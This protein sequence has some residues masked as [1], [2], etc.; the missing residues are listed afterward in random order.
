[1][2]WNTGI[3]LLLLAALAVSAPADA[4][5]RRQQTKKK[6]EQK[7]KKDSKKQ[8]GKTKLQPENPRPQR[9]TG[10]ND[11]T[12]RSTTFE[13]EQIYKPEIKPTP[14]P[15]LTPTMPPAAVQRLNQQ[16]EVPQQALNYTYRSLPIRPL[17]LGKDTATPPPASYIKA[18]GGNLSTIFGDIG[19]GGFKGGNWE[20][21]FHAHHISQKGDI[22]GQKFWHTGLDA[23]GTLHTNGH[24]WKALLDVDY[25]RVG[26]Y[27]Y[28][29]DA[30]NYSEDN[31]NRT[32]TS[33]GLLLG[34]K[35]EETGVLGLD[36]DAFI[37]ANFSAG[38]SL[39]GER[40]IELNVPVSKKIDESFSV[41]LGMNALLTQLKTDSNQNNN[42]FQLTPAF[43][44]MKEQFAAHFGLSPTF[45]KG[46]IAY[47]LPDIT[48]GYQ[49]NDHFKVNAGWQAK[50]IQNTFQ[51]LY[52]RNMFL[53]G[54]QKV[55]QTRSDEVF[56]AFEAGIGKH[57]SIN[58][59]VSWWQYDNL[60]MYLTDSMADGKTFMVVYEPR[61]NA[62][63]F[64][65]AMRYQVATT[66]SVGLSGAYFGYY[67]KRGDKLW[68]EPA[69]RFKGD[70]QWSP[71]KD[72]QINAYFSLLDQIFAVTKAGSEVKLNGVAD[73]GLGGEY[74]LIPQ[75]SLW[76]NVNN[77]TNRKNER[78]LNYEGFG[79]NVYGGLRF[80]F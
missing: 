5:R 51:Q 80:R 52:L 71:L 15:E 37:R 26:L 29:H 6:V 38:T 64:Q 13:V 14:K 54:P 62:I 35:N 50:L 47:L 61:V 59:R 79:I 75:L 48:A 40:T 77:L 39:N 24:A 78:W 3:C 30:Y 31:L 46:G 57:I 27:G 72:L 20:S 16:Y 56:G 45:G 36:Y 9:N 12:I 58:A 44:Y 73:L 65:A 63:S 49:V 22:T 67:N 69:V 25:R 76:V 21:A 68:N 28:D 33:G 18:G 23:S 8:V 60:P 32:Y 2:K 17:A 7:A 1:M 74:Q 43:N 70:F 4:Q 66:L 34:V 11:T 41:A 10:N 55:Q 42:I 19:I 53:F